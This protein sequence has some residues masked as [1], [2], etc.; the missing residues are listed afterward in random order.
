MENKESADKAN[1]VMDFPSLPAHHL[2]FQKLPYNSSSF[3]WSTSR[4]HVVN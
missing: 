4:T 1:V 3:K 2:D